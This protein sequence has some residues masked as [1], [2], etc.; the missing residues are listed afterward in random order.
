MHR[1]S[2]ESCFIISICQ[3]GCFKGRSAKEAFIIDSFV[4][5]LKKIN[6]NFK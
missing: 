3:Q 6:E 5:R 1:K 4:E 2:Q